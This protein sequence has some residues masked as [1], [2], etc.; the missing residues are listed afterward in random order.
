MRSIANADHYTWG[1]K[2]DGWYLLE[3]E[4]LSVIEE[5]MPGNTS[6]LLH[7][8]RF[9]QQVFYILSGVATFDV[10]GERQIISAHESIHVPPGVLHRIANCH[11][12]DLTFLVISQPRSHDDRIEI[13]GNAD[14]P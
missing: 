3:S 14:E 11:D 9:A 4:N 6:E 12:S 7:F 2:C 1:S 10:G 8:H 5:R 13:V